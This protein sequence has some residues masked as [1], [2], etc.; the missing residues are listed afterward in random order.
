MCLASGSRLESAAGNSMQGAPKFQ[1]SAALVRGEAWRGH[2][3][4]WEMEMCWMQVSLARSAH[5]SARWFDSGQ[6]EISRKTCW[7]SLTLPPSN[8]HNQHRRMA[9]AAQNATRGSHVPA[10]SFRTMRFHPYFSYPFFSHQ[11]QTHEAHPE[12]L[13]NHNVVPRIV[14]RHLREMPMLREEKKKATTIPVGSCDPTP[15]ESLHGAPTQ[16]AVRSCQ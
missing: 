16:K 8:Q 4:M 2:R 5:A 15:S 10:G 11:T 13:A 6:G 9:G 1:Y 12:E 3:A 7:K 14:G